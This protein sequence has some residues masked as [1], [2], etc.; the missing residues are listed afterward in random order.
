MAADDGLKIDIR[1]NKILEL[2]ARDGKVR[3]SHL[4]QILDVSEVTIRNDLSELEKA[5]HL[6]RTSGGAV[7]TMK[8]FYNMDFQRR[9]HHKAEF[10]QA[11]GC[12]AADL[13]QDGETLM[14][15]SGTTTFFTAIELKKHKNINIVTNSLAIAVELGEYPTFRVILLGGEINSHYSFTYGN[16]ALTQLK[17]YKADKCILSVDGVSCES[18]LTTYHAQEAEVNISMMERS[19]RTII[20]ADYTKLETESF[21]NICDLSKAD[22]WVTNNCAN[23]EL[24]AKIRERGIEIVTC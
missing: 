23:E 22:Y 2:L 24:L 14:I 1:R 18:G 16:D 6:E 9:K 12:A 17:K 7:L 5:G 13:V 11:I 19:R 8:N 15:N 21:F 4:K 3:V 10:K 20:V